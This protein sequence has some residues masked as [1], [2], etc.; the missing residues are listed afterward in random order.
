MLPL[1]FTSL[2]KTLRQMMLKLDSSGRLWEAIKADVASNAIHSSF[3]FVLIVLFYLLLYSPLFFPVV[4]GVEWRRT[5]YIWATS[6]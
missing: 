1:K 4:K 2:I 6:S 5:L 3:L